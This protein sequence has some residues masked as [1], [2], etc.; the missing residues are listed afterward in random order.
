MLKLTRTQRIL[1]ITLLTIP[2]LVA[3]VPLALHYARPS[4]ASPSFTPP[5]PATQ[6]SPARPPLR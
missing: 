3:L 2:E 6:A 4:H 1:I 5:T